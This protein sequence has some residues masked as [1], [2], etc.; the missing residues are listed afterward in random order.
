MRGPLLPVAVFLGLHR[1]ETG[2]GADS[3]IHAPIMTRTCD[4]GKVCEGFR[5]ERD[6]LDVH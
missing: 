5:V 2:K 6:G 3:L 4:T 1:L